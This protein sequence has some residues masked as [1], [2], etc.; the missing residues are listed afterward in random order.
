ME[1]EAGFV[2]EGQRAA[3]LRVARKPGK[4]KNK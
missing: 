3:M 1:T 4:D 2:S